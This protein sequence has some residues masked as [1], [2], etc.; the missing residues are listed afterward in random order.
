MEESRKQQ[1]MSRAIRDIVSE[2]IMSDISDPRMSG[3]VTITSIDLSP[4]LHY[5][6][7]YLRCFGT[8]DEADKKK[9][10]LAIDHARGFIQSK[11]AA[12]LNVRSCP[13]I[14]FHEDVKQEKVDQMMK[15]IA[16]VNKGLKDKS[17]GDEFEDL[18][19]ADE[20]EK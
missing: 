20:S 17:P 13:I 7:V 4:D 6:S 16:E 11:L 19:D 3:F 18:D 10:F 1:R 15:L 2:A 12:E 5:A 9:T 8:K 14:S